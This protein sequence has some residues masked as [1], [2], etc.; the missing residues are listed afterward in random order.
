[1]H[2]DEVNLSIHVLLRHYIDKGRRVNSPDKQ[3]VKPV[4]LG[5]TFEIS[6]RVFRFNLYN[7]QLHHTFNSF[8]QRSRGHGEKKKKRILETYDI[9]S[10][11]LVFLRCT[12]RTKGVMRVHR[13]KASITNGRIPGTG[14]NLTYTLCVSE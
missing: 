11:L 2:V 14:D 1:M 9:M 8:I 5:D 10:T 6:Y 3:Y 13:T 4:H 12:I 7:H